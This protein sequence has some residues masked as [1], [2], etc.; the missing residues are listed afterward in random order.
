MS[1]LSDASFD[2]PKSIGT[3]VSVSATA[4]SLLIP[5]ALDFHAVRRLVAVD[6]DEIDVQED[7]NGDVDE[8]GEMIVEAAQAL[9]YTERVG[10]SAIDV[11]PEGS[12]ATLFDADSPEAKELKPR[13]WVA[14]DTSARPATICALLVA[15]EWSVDDSLS[16]TRFTAAYCRQHALPRLTTST[17][18]IDMVTSRRG[19]RTRGA[20][21]L[22][23]LSCYLLVC[24]SPKYSRLATVAVTTKGIDLFTNLGFQVHRF[25][26][27]GPRAFCWADAKSL[28][29][30]DLHQRLQWDPAVKDI[31]WRSGYTRATSSRKIGRC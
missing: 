4:K 15:C 14:I 7:D 6:G 17:L 27:G 16:T 26:E 22:L 28:K 11:S 12:L 8:L 31:C 21:A 25:R 2:T 9:R 20:A 24:R 10:N 19:N 5:R 29:A 18:F 23:V 1:G 30:A 3:F 13:L